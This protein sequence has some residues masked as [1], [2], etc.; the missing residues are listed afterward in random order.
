MPE[1][2]ERVE[3]SPEA[4]V[5]S[6]PGEGGDE[7]VAKAPATC[8]R[9]RRYKQGPSRAQPMRLPPSVEDYVGEDNLV[10][11][12]TAYVDSLDLAALSF[13]YAAGAP[14]AGQPAYA[15]A[16]LLKRYLYGYLN[17]ARSSQRLG[18]E[19]RRNLELMWRPLAAHRSSPGS[20]TLRMASIQRASQHRLTHV[21]AK[22]QALQRI[23][24]RSLHHSALGCH[25]GQQ[26]WPAGVRVLASEGALQ[27]PT[28][29]ATIASSG[30]PKKLAAIQSF[31]G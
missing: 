12:I 19:C 2:C 1:H 5:L 21:S 16:D 27:R 10:R 15:P 6:L 7:R 11:A 22:V 9:G 3:T 18:A 4:F 13:K 25:V 17:R 8:G 29:C 24:S 23:F 28:V 26:T 20:G 31:A 30:R 14:G